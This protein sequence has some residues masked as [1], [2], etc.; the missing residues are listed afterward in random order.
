MSWLT[1]FPRNRHQDQLHL[2]ERSHVGILLP[3]AL[4][5]IRH[6]TD[7]TGV[8]AVWRLINLSN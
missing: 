8:N 5:E 6:L 4:T 3:V 2:D 1:D 7:T